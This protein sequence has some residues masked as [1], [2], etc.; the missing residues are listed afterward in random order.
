VLFYLKIRV[1][2]RSGNQN[3]YMEMTHIEEDRVAQ[4]SYNAIKGKLAFCLRV[5]ISTD[6]TD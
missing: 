6:C 1:T 4:E 3:G 2:K 5:V